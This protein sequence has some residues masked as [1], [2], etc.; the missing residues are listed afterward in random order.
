[1]RASDTPFIT[2]WFAVSLRWL[3]LM[4]AVLS[5]AFGGDLLALPNLLLVI[6][7]F[8]NLLLTLLAGLNVRMKY[9]RQASLGLDLSIVAAY[10]VVSGGFT[11]PT[12]WLGVLPLLTAVLYYEWRGILV[13][14]PLMIIVQFGATVSQRATLSDL[15][16]PMGSSVLLIL[17]GVVFGLL[18]TSLIRTIRHIRQIQLDEQRE[19]QRIENERMRAIYNLTSTLTSTLNYQRVLDSV[20]DLSLSAVNT[21]PDS[22]ADDRLVS[23]VMLFSKNDV[24]EFASARRL[25]PA[26]KRASLRGQ[27]GAIGKAI[28]ED[29]PVLVKDIKNDPELC[30]IVTFLACKE[31][32]CF[33]LRSGFNAYGILIFGHPDPGY[34]TPDRRET[35][36]I[37]G[38]QAVIA[39]QNARLYQ[40]LVDER[41]RMIDLQEE[42]RKKLA[43]DLH[44]GP[45]Q[46]VSA[47]AMRV[48]LVQRM[49]TKD[50]EYA[51]SELGKIEELARRTTKE[52]RHMLFTLRPLVLE[53]QGLVAALKSMAEKTN[54]TY[55]QDVQIQIDE[56]VLQNMEVGKQSVV[57]YIAEEAVT[58][59]RKHA[60]AAHVWVH[61]R[62]YNKE[63]ALLE[64]QDDG[65]GFDVAAVTRAYDQRGSLG[66]VNLRERTELVNGVLNIQS[67]PGKGTRVQVYIPLTEEAA[68][69]LHHAVQK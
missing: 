67:A 27:A 16:I 42:T 54:E 14:V 29:K 69:R 34:F 6:L 40:D 36:D 2:D 7:L 30:R 50:P 57:F 1:M 8:W 51:G 48:N 47:I 38:S 18:G 10:F 32:Y 3:V 62:P 58:N 22:A 4:G 19:K 41:D 24:L 28:E 33:P 23:V 9:H 13:V 53:S 25:T 68:D 37:L 17:L 61:L 63:I 31:I 66:M 44:D 35:L 65:I 12:W 15:I 59:A 64:I 55:A 20:L 52:I 56:S 5:I 60:K 39:I 49:L 11:V 26:D 45:T 43:R 46:S 21:D